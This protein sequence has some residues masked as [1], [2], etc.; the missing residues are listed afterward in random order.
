MLEKESVIL[1][2]DNVVTT[3]IPT[4][5]EEEGLGRVLKELQAVGLRNVLIVDG[6]S[7]DRTV[8]IARKFGA[9]VIYQHGKGK[10]GAIKTA[11]DEVD[12]PYMLIIDGDFSYDTSCVPRL[13]F[14]MNSHDEVIGARV[15]DGAN[16]SYLHRFGNKIITKVF[17]ILMNADLSDVCSGMY[18]LRSDS[19]RD[20]HLASKGFEVEVEIA[21]QIA[22]SGSITEVPVNYRPRIGKQKLS[23]WKHGFKILA[24][25]FAVARTY[26]PAVFYTILGTLLVIPGGS[27]LLATL[28]EWA[29]TGDVTMHWFLIGISMF[30]V[31]MQAMGV[32][33]V[34]LILRRTELRTTRMLKKILHPNV[35]ANRM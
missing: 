27:I 32:G 21:A 10:A 30:L 34:S 17:N 15:L 26:N 14:H 12:T 4:L 35:Y 1:E 28:M 18:L 22:S 13:L 5:N 8:D 33:V 31:S 16:M 3:V 20:I 11:I 25:I 19:A 24:G 9:R 6:Y 23:T 7:S 29:R 2:L